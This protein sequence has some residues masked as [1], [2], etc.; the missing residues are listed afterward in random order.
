[1]AGLAGI[2]R[3]RMSAAERGEILRLAET[4]RRPTP[5][6]IARRLNRHPATVAWFMIRQG[7]IERTLKYC[8]QGGGQKRCAGGV[9]RNPYMPDHDRRLIELRLQGKV[10]REI[11]AAL[12]AEFGVPRNMHSVQVRHVMLSAYEGGPEG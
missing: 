11:A 10:Y 2:K 4:L 1:M 7:I 9:V 3:G 8:S 6:V 5:S 12:T